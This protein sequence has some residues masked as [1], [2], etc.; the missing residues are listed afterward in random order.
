MI[1]IGKLPG[2]RRLVAG[3]VAV[4][5]VSGVLG[6]F[7]AA[8]SA[9]AATWTQQTPA[10][11]PPARYGAS[12][13]YDAATGNVVLFGGTGVAETGNLDDTWTWNGS[14]WTQ[15]T[16]ATSPPGLY[17]ASMAYDAATGNVVLFG[18]VTSAGAVES[19]TWTWDGSTWT[20]QAPATSPPALAMATMAYDP[21]SGQLVLFGG[22]TDFSHYLGGTWIWN[23]STWARQ[24]PATSPPGRYEAAMTY[25][26]TTSSVVLFGGWGK[27]GR[28]GDTWAWDGSDWTNQT[29]AAHPPVRN[30]PAIAYDPASG[31]IVLF[32]GSGA[33]TKGKG[34][35][36]LGDTW[37]WDGSTW[38][39]QSPATSP[40]ARYFASLVYDPATSNDVLFGGEPS[41]GGTPFGDTWTWG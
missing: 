27:H 22:S 30:F 9:Q 28:L 12:M 39:E 10:T 20:H 3:A 6:A 17:G 18:G 16:P 5:G 24:S 35:S 33:G 14:T 4:L 13:A 11:S 36:I 8:A 19:G 40:A 15:Q 38:T 31:G 7:P 25:D 34:S 26:P 32:G 1:R 29:P 21:A 2:G 41:P 37:I 23:G